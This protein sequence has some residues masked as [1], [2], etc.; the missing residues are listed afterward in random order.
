MQVYVYYKSMSRPVSKALF[1]HPPAP[2]SQAGVRWRS[3]P[4]FISALCWQPKSEDRILLAGSSHG[5]LQL[6]KLVTRE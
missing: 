6:L 1:S 2:P 4:A 5:T 3:G